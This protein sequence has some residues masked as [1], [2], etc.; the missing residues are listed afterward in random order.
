MA[1][2]KRGHQALAETQ[3]TLGIENEIS[4]ET[5]ATVDVVVLA[6]DIKIRKMDRFLGKPIVEVRV[7]EAIR[8]ADQIIERV[9]GVIK[10]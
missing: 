3:G 7:A 6:A 1:A 5:A 2:R 8:K 4:R 9:E 10:T